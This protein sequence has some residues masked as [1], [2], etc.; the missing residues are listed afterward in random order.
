[1]PP[2]DKICHLLIIKSWYMHA[3]VPQDACAVDVIRQMHDDSPPRVCL[4]SFQSS[5]SSA[6]YG[7]L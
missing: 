2:K 1:M 3:N 4:A 7:C 5:Q 6:A